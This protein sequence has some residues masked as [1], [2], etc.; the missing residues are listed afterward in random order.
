MK[1]PQIYHIICSLIFIIIVSCSKTENFD[2]LANGV[3]IVPGL[4]VE[5]SYLINQNINFEVYDTN[6]T[7]I[8]S[9]VTFYVDNNEIIGSNI[10]FDNIS[11]HEVYAEYTIDNQVFNTEVSNFSIVEPKTKVL[12]ED[13]TGTWCGYC[14]PVGHAIQLATE[15]LGAENIVVVATHQNDQYNILEEQDLSDALSIGGLP[16]ARIN[17]TTEWQPPYEISEIESLFQIDNDIAISIDS[18]TENLNLNIIVRLVS[19][20]LIMNNKIVVY[21][22]ENNLISDQ[23]NYLNSDE[24]SFFYNMGNPIEGY[25]HDHVLRYPFTYVTGDDLSQINPLTDYYFNYSYELSQNYD[26][27]NLGIVVI[28]TN[29]ENNAIN[30]QYSVINEFQD[31]D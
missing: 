21:L 17:R 2:S 10:S 24:T 25:I 5:S 6:Q 31:F 11:E 15:A 20:D 1:K 14:P 18:D 7:N 23:A 27:E 30:S 9:T 22:V 19:K 8:T 26:I 12:I 29:Q 16:E 13:F 4:N 3:N 28:V